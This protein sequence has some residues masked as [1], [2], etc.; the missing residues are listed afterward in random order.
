MAAATEPVALKILFIGNTNVGKSSLLIRFTDH[1]FHATGQ[2]HA[3][4][5]VDFKVVPITVEEQMVKLTIWV[6]AKK[7]VKEVR[8]SRIQQDRKDLELLPHRITEEL[9]ESFLYMM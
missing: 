8:K 4:I 7:G 5:G 3:T 6:R 9:K 2:L 1:T